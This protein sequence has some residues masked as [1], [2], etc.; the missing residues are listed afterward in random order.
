[1]SKR[2]VRKH[3]ALRD[4]VIGR[5]RL[6]RSALV[7]SLTL[8]AARSN[9]RPALFR[10]TLWKRTPNALET[11]ACI[12]KVD[13]IQ[14]AICFWKK[15]I[16]IIMFNSYFPGNQCNTVNVHCYVFSTWYKYRNKD[17]NDWKIP[18]FNKQ[19]MWTQ[20]LL[21]PVNVYTSS[22]GYQ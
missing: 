13:I 17:W 18:C 4:R 7:V 14:K 8:N 11:T 5:K 3:F 12:A 9:N 22:L 1:M 16:I 19:L 2:N 21:A 10:G 20:V 15:Y 6:E